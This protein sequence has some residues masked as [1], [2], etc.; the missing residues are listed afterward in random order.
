[1]AA[2]ETPTSQ[3]KSG[4]TRT[5]P[6]HY[7]NSFFNSPAKSTGSKKRK[8]R[9]QSTQQKNKK[10]NKQSDN[11]SVTSTVSAD[12]SAR[13]DM[14]GRD[15]TCQ[16]GGSATTER[17][18]LEVPDQGVQDAAQIVQDEDNQSKGDND[19]EGPTMATI[20]EEDEED[21]DRKEGSTLDT[22]KERDNEG[23]FA[24]TTVAQ[25]ATD[26]EPPE[27]PQE[28]F[29]DT[30]QT[31]P[32][33]KTPDGAI[34]D[35]G[36]VGTFLDIGIGEFSPQRLDSRPPTPIR[37]RGYATEDDLPL[38]RS[39][40]ER[41]E[42][43]KYKEP[44]TTLSHS[45]IKQW[46]PGALV[47]AVNDPESNI[48]IEVAN[49]ADALFGEDTL[50]I[51]RVGVWQDDRIIPQNGL[52]RALGEF[53]LIRGRLER[54]DRVVKDFCKWFHDVGSGT[55]DLGQQEHPEDTTGSQGRRRNW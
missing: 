36:S 14:V 45:M 20:H 31:P 6:K 19:K 54:E 38:V 3:R 5:K 10:K 17:S 32:L 43:A 42:N 7:D 12:D 8:N 50:Q 55:L 34:R 30:D 51:R 9:N 21:D 11:G 1:M 37:D 27:E 39:W 18:N 2:D 25:N 16:H 46:V 29:D 44:R 28:P 52:S 35:N 33:P 4:R 24:P 49:H 15:I 23:H 13:E 26:T 48:L 41:E 53:Q 40:F 22:T 47:V